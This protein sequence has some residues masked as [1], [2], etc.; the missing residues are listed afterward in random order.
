MKIRSIALTNFR[1]FVGTV[2]IDGIGDGVSVLVGRNEIGKSTILEAMNGVI[3]AK[4]KSTA[5]DVKGYRHFV[6]GTVPEVELG[7]EL[8]GENWTIRKRFAGQGGK[9]LLTSRN[10]RFEDEAAEAE[11]QRLL[12]FTGGRGAAEPGIWGTLWVRQGYSFGPPGLNE[13]A[14]RT[15]QDCLETQVG[16]VTGGARGHNI[17]NAVKASLAEIVN[18]RGPYGRF[19]DVRDQLAAATSR[20]DELTTKRAELFKHMDDLARLTK[21]LRNLK[22]DWDEVAYR[23]ELADTRSMATAAATKAA[24][25]ARM[26]SSV[27]LAEQRAL[28]AQTSVGERI[29]LGAE[30]DRV[31]KAIRDAE[32]QVGAARDTKVAAQTDLDAHESTIAGLREKVRSISERSR[33]LDRIRAA[34]AI[35]AE[36]E[37][38]EATIIKVASLEGEATG[39]S[40]SIGR[41]VTTQDAV[42]RIETA[43]TDLAAAEAALN[44]VATTLSFDLEPDAR[45]EIDGARLE[46]SK[47]QRPIVVKT[48]ISVQSVGKIVVEPHIRNRESILKKVATAREELTTALADAGADDLAAA[49]RFAAQR[50]EL[51]RQLTNVRREIAALAPGDKATKLPAGLDAIRSRLADRRGRLETETTA[52]G[53]T[54]LPSVVT[55]EE[56]TAESHR[57]AESGAEEL[58]LAEA[59][60]TSPQANLAQATALVRT[61]E[62]EQATLRGNLETIEATLKAARDRLSDAELIA[63]SDAFEQDAIKQQ[64]ALGLMEREAGEPLDAINARIRRLEGAGQHH[65]EEITRLNTEITRLTA[66]IEVNEGAGIEETLEA[67]RAD[68]TRLEAAVKNY[69][70][71]AAVLRLLLDTLRVAESEAKTRYLTPVVS[72]VEPYLKMLLPAAD[73]VLDENLGITALARDGAQEDFECLSGGTQEQIAV[74]T[75]LAFA[76]LLLAQ[77]RPATVILDD[78]LAFSDDDRIERMFDILVRAGQHVQIIV[79]TCRKRL[80]TRLGADTLQIRDVKTHPTVTPYQSD[81]CH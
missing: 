39:L 34:L 72:R 63:Q 3:F 25:I 2:R 59:G 66:L 26:R 29:H 78:A 60:L 27:D 9:A 74:L 57:E 61:Q 23:Q 17:P 51:Q 35:Q 47:T 55:V 1:K 21:E 37:R 44:A 81:P 18:S 30:V 53:L 22:A 68:Q 15:L 8:D 56:E 70:Q 20:I 36:I 42:Q 7:F 54:D 28:A 50:E 13:S 4:A 6:N 41:I 67:T 71:E 64:T 58:R 43:T 19:K 49:R 12:G 80:F 65:Q 24:D 11:L 46:Q 62:Q 75:R 5:Q 31:G 48:I 10:R 76:E 40:E 77:G 33:R 32:T 45:V 38:H 14:R 69:E 79:L 16:A 52:L 73:I